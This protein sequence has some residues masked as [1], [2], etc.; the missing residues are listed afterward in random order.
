V[1]KANEDCLAWTAYQDLEDLLD[2]WA[3]KERKETVVYKVSQA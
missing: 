3:D 1:K 2:K